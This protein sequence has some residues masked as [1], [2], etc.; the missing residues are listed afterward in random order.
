MPLSPSSIEKLHKD[1]AYMKAL[2]L[3]IKG[4]CSQR[5]VVDSCDNCATAKRD[6]CRSNVDQLIRNFVEVTLK[7]NLLET[8]YMEQGV[9]HEHRVAHNRAHL[10]MAEQLQQV[11]AVFSEDGNSLIA[12]EGIDQ[13]LD[14]LEAHARDFDEPMEAYLQTA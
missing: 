2:I 12:I 11:R 7:H 13:M 10:E 4:M 9:P 5:G 8:L 6:V 14:C 3:R 1:H